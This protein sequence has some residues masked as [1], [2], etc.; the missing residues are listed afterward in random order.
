MKLVAIILIAF[1]LVSPAILSAEEVALTLDEAISIALRDNREVLL[2]AEDIKKAKAKIAEAKAGLLPTLNFTGGWTD[3]GGYYNKDIGQ[4]TTQTTLKQYLYKGGKTINTI[5]QNKYK[6]EVSQALL[7]K[8][9]LETVLNIKKAFYTLLLAGEFSNLNKGILN[10]TQEY[11]DSI[12]ARYR[13]GQVSESD[14]LKMESSLNTVIEA[15][16]ATLNQVEASAAILRNLLYLDDK[17]K[18]KP[19]NQF[20]YEPKAVA[21]DEGFLQAMKTR[22]EIRQY[23]AQ[24]KVDKKAIEITKADN[25]P[26]I[27]ASWDYYSRSHT[28]ATTSKNWNDYN[29]IGLTFSWPIFDGWA[30]KAKV[31][32]AITDLKETQL[33]KE[34]AIKDI[35][36]ELKNAYLD[37]KNAIEKIKSVQAQINLYKD[38]LL[39]IQDKYNAGIAS[40][41]D[42]NDASLGYEVSL[43]NQKQAIYDYVLA[44]SRF[45]KATG[46]I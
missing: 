13:N 31:E 2:N 41:L 27:Y 33:T 1:I 20:V 19:A 12:K 3:T 30:T 16:E 15:Y 40:S 24:E 9:K 28:S 11:L 36:L 42:L 21:Y 5:E 8:T 26:S 45:D 7:D 23:E 6:L 32:Q 4:T 39:V 29:I 46:G 18:V 14:I 10:N 22:P 34:K 17:V 37:L 38:T 43:F 35:A 25:R 44:K